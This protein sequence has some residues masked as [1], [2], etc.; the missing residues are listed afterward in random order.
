M[1]ISET[2]HEK[3]EHSTERDQLE[4]KHKATYCDFYYPLSNIKTAPARIE[5]SFDHEYINASEKP[6]GELASTLR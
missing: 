4:C 5:E 2:P 6:E 3:L 1:A